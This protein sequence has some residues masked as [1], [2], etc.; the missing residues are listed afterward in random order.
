MHHGFCQGMCTI[1][2]LYYVCIVFMINDA[3]RKKENK[4]KCNL[5]VVNH[6]AV[7]LTLHTF[8]RASELNS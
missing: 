4:K 8:L 1:Y 6:V 7:I 3:C 5:S 2:D